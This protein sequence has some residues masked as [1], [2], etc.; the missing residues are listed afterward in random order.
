[1]INVLKWN[2]VAAVGNIC[3]ILLSVGMETHAEEQPLSSRLAV[4]GGM[5]VEYMNAIDIVD[6]VNAQAANAGASDRVEEFKSGVVF[7]GGVSMPLDTDFVIK[8]E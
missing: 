1:M 5:G 8:A 6:Y 7:F 2:Q 3:L 4:S